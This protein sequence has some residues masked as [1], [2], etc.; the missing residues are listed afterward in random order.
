VSQ[1]RRTLRLFRVHRGAREEGG[2]L[3]SGRTG[4]V[5]A[6][7]LASVMLLFA[8]VPAIDSVHAA[9]SNTP[10]GIMVPLFSYLGPAWS[11]LIAFHQLYPT[12]PVI[13]VVDPGRGPGSFRD[14][15]F[16]LGVQSLQNAGIPVLGYVVT[17]YANINLQSVEATI[18]DYSSWYHVNGAML[19]QMNNTQGGEGYYSTL[20]NFDRSLGMTMT[21]GNPGT[22]VPSSFVGSVDTIV[23]YESPSVPTIGFIGGWHASYPK[24]NWIITAYDVEDLNAT[25]VRQASQ[26]LGYLYITDGVWPNPYT[27]LP[28]Y[29]NTL[30]STLASVDG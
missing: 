10:T 25:W 11:Q 8:F 13:A 21:V 2:E 23:I 27:G 15:N 9:P 7:L 20:T 3:S 16:Q 14:P 18:T 22:E 26:Y 1:K 29:M 17:D 12:V 6:S 19:D 5:Y 4:L 30:M 28:S 24:A